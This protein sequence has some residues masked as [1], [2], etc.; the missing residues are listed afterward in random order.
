MLAELALVEITDEAWSEAMPYVDQLREI[1]SEYELREQ[2]PQALGYAISALGFARAGAGDE[3]RRAWQQARQLCAQVTGTLPWLAL[4]TV[5]VLA[6]V[7]LLLGDVAT[8]RLLVR[9]AES[10]LARSPGWGTLE[11]RLD[12]VRRAASETTSI[13]GLAVTPLTTA[14]LRV[15]RY[16]PPTSPSP[17]SPTSCSCRATP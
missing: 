8:A 2:P 6:R 1:V 13:A 14:E 7:S 5:E 15:L 9:E 17:P 4:E 12:E 11:G 10:L 3:A 16:L